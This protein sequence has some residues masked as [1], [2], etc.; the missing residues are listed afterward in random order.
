MRIVALTASPDHVC[1]RY[2]V[3]AFRPFFEEAGHELHIEPLSSHWWLPWSFGSQIAQAD[4]VIVQ[5]RLLPRWQLFLLRRRARRLIFDFDDAVFRRDSYD[6]RGPYSRRRRHRFRAMVRVA[7]AVIAGNDFLAD[8]ARRY[9]DSHRVHVIPTCVNPQAYPLAPHAEDRGVVRLA[10]IGSATTLRGLERIQPVLDD[11]G[12]TYP[13]LRLQLICNKLL[14][15]RTLPVDFQPWSQATEARDLAS[16]DIGISWLPD[17]DWSRGKCGLKILQYMAAGLPVVANSVGV[18]SE[19]VESGVTGYRADT[20]AG[21]IEA[22]GRLVRNAAL[23]RHLGRAR[24]QRVEDRYHV[25]SGGE[26]WLDIL[27]RLVPQACGERTQL[28]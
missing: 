27:H 20:P 13:N 12:R 23:R 18:Q 11:L 19:M 4:A 21:W 5:R 25:R 22:V 16:A 2:R 7:D 26:H 3:A 15:L 9:T 10:W 24:R 28:T 8:Y 1:T 6:P 17:D 14:Q